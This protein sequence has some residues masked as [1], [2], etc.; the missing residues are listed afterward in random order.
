MCGK[1]RLRV[2]SDIKNS[3]EEME[4]CD[5]EGLVK[6]DPRNNGDRLENM[7]LLAGFSVLESS[8][9]CWVCLLKGRPEL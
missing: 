8:F 3:R 9:S 5:A 1:Q 7:A 4:H 6:K 2:E